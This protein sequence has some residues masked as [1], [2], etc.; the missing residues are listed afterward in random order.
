MAGQTFRGNAVTTAT[1]DEVW[2]KFND[3]ATWEG[4]PGV[5]RVYDEVRDPAGKLVGF[6]FDSS[7]IGKT[8]AGKASAGPRS[9]GKSLTW[10]IETSELR[11]RIVAT[12]DSV[13]GGT[14]VD[15]LLEVR[16]VSMMASFGFPLVAGAISRGFQETV[17]DF[18]SSL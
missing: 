18:T 6:S 17:D 3:P 7:A 9:E 10:E 4:I 16:P 8:Y 14:L 11:G 15:V 2:E 12:T 5:D 1:T 13:A